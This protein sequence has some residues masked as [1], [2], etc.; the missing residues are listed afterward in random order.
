MSS[1]V[2][3]VLLL[4]NGLAGKSQE[5]QSTTRAAQQL[6]GLALAVSRSLSC[7]KAP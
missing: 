7:S 6:C 3:A 5:K 4:V 1:G 2:D